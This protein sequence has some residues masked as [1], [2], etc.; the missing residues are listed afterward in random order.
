MGYPFWVTNNNL[1]SY[2]AGTSLTLAPISLIFGE[3][4]S[5]PCTLQVLNGSLPPGIM[6][7]QS[8]FVIVLQGELQAVGE[9]VSYQFTL[10]VSNG[11]HVADRT[12]SITT[13]QTVSEFSWITSNSQPLLYV[14]NDQ[15]DSAQIQAQCLPLQYVEYACTNLNILT[16]GIQLVPD[17]GAITVDIA[18]R[19][20]TNYTA[21]KD[22]V[23]QNDR[24]YECVLSGIS[25]STLGPQGTGS[26]IVD[27]VYAAWQPDRLYT[28]NSVV[29][30]D[31]GKLYKCRLPGISNSTPGAGPTGTSTNIEDGTCEWSYET[32][33]LVWDQVPE[34]TSINLNLLCVANAG[35]TSIS[36]SFTIT[37]VSREA[38][39]FWLTPAGLI[40]T[41]TPQQLFTFQLQVQDPDQSLL[42]WSST[43]LPS[44]LQLTLIGEVI[45]QAP[46]VSQNTSFLFDV[47]VS[48]GIHTSSRS[49]E[50]LVAQEQLVLSWIT[51]SQLPDITD[52]VISYLFVQAQSPLP[53]TFI[54]YGLA[55]GILPVGLKLDNQTGSL[56]G[57]VEFQ[58]QDKTYHFEV[59]AN[60]GVD[61]IIRQFQVNVISISKAPYWSL[62]VPLW[63][64]F[65]NEIINS[66][67]NSVINDADLYLLNEPAWGR[68][69]AP[70]VTIIS[71]LKACS[72][73]QF[74]YMISDYMHEWRMGFQ[75]LSVTSLPE[76]P[77]NTVNIQVQ[78]GVSTKSWQPNTYYPAS[79]RIAAPSG[80]QYQTASA[81]ESGSTIPD[82]QSDLA[83]DG[84]ISWSRIFNPNT[85]TGRSAPLPWYPYHSYRVGETVVREGHSYVSIQPGR[86]GGSWP[87]ITSTQTQVLDN[88]VIWQKQ[89]GSPGAN[90]YWPS[91]VV[92]M[93]QILQSNLSWSNSWGSGAQASIRVNPAT[94]ACVAVTVT[95][96]GTGY[97]SAPLAKIISSTG[98]QSKLVCK[99]GILAVDILQSDTGVIPGSQI[100]VDLGTGD[101]AVIQ[102]VEV[103]TFNQAT[104][105][106]VITSGAYSKVPSEPFIILTGTKQIK[107]RFQVGV[108]SIQVAMPGSGYQASDLVDFSGQEWDPVRNTFIDDYSLN[109]CLAF[110]SS[111][112]PTLNTTTN[113]YQG[114]I[115]PV[116]KV[117]AELQGITWQ[118]YTRFDLDQTHFDASGTR[119]IEVTPITET[120]WDT[121]QTVW[122]NQVTT[123]DRMPSVEY[124]QLPFTV[125]DANKTLFDYFETVFDQTPPTYE[126]RWKAS[127]VWFMGTHE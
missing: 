80:Q 114:Q 41:C 76:L 2:P 115:I 45:G 60:D 85:S 100:T 64:D 1:G 38:A 63:G 13:T 19:P 26:G 81:G 33:A 9:T 10:R 86:S 6:Y 112:T 91:C 62:S 65:K 32:Q 58:G 123:F 52:G 96:S 20:L 88:T 7:I 105:I 67:T 98:T 66:N 15:A 8:G 102:V 50:I 44:W 118:G 90:Q 43:N 23:Y 92:N 113:P 82:F 69:S 29:S 25:S 21:S 70:S 111:D 48:D 61:T 78:D 24:L 16:K 68:V 4:E 124:T 126:S 39:P 83:T 107:V 110:V 125:F 116:T 72:P 56:Q 51:P 84:Q 97:Y 95:N 93:R 104:K 89:M 14:Y 55:G 99:V 108:N 12:F 5:L 103:N 49:F 71:G 106:Q 31:L 117:K 73:D 53:G 122:D 54:T 22:F 17:S 59:M 30:N 42:V 74:R 75:Q 127:W 120:I 101:P 34:D 77:Y 3:S 46:I 36:R 11:T 57:F 40:L 87:T 37:L 109:M 47:T 35:T 121:Q 79:A 94:G 27:S 18:W 119:F 28:I